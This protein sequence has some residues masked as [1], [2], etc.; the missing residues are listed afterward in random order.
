MQDLDFHFQAEFF[1]LRVVRL[2]QHMVNA[3]R[4]RIPTIFVLII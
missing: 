1:V 2:E 3:L 4:F